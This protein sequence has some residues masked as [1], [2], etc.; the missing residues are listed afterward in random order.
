MGRH[1]EKLW[2]LCYCLA[3]IKTVVRRR[4]LVQGPLCN[5][6]Y[7]LQRRQV[8]SRYSSIRQH[9]N[10][11]KKGGECS[12][13][14]GHKRRKGV[15]VHVSV[16]TEG[17]PLS[18]VLSPGNE[19]DSKRFIEVLDGIRIGKD[20]GRPRSRPMEV[21]ADAAYDNLEIR[22]YLR[23]RGIKSNIP[24]NKRNHK[25]PKIGR[26]TRFNRQ[27]YGLRGAVE[28]FFGWLKSG[29]RRLALRYE[30]LNICFMGLL[31]LACFII[32]WRRVNR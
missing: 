21:L 7:S 6:R 3:K 22:S 27:S 20:I 26:P 16:S 17:L 29:F 23:R 18:I 5:L 12:S 28:R 31:I 25:A 4:S 15:K 13:Y 8:V 19:H 30:R 9:L 10:R 11:F 1:A 14:N 32:Y 2:V 24:R